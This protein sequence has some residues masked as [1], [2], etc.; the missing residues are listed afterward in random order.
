MSHLAFI[1]KAISSSDFGLVTEHML[2][3]ELVKRLVLAYNEAG[4]WLACFFDYALAHALVSWGLNQ[5][6]LVSVKSASHIALVEE[7]T[8]NLTITF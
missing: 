2:T 7:Q 6:F 5:T 8:T 1:S 3:S 4:L